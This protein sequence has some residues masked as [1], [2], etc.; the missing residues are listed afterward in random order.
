MDWEELMEM[1]VGKSLGERVYR[2]NESKR[3]KI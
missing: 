2:K 1:M 3:E